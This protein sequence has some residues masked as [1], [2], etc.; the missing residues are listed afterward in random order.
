M[1]ALRHFVMFTQSGV[2]EQGVQ[3]GRRDRAGK[4]AQQEGRQR[5]GD[6]DRPG[7]LHDSI[8]MC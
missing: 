7:T 1:S 3:G 2:D 8:I 5:R 6:R 4:L